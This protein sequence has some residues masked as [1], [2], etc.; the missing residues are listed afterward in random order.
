MGKK[1]ALEDTPAFFKV[2]LGNFPK[3][4]QIPPAF[5]KFFYGKPLPQNI[6]LQ[7][8]EKSL[9]QVNVVKIGNKLF[10]KKGWRA[11]VKDNSLELG[12]FV[13]FSY[14]G[15]SIFGFTIFGRN[16]C[17]KD[18]TAVPRKSDKFVSDKGMEKER[19]TTMNN[20]QT[21]EDGILGNEERNTEMSDVDQRGH[22]RMLDN[23][24]RLGKVS[25][26]N[27]ANQCDSKIDDKPVEIKIEE[28]DEEDAISVEFVEEIPKS[29][30]K[31]KRT[32]SLPSVPSTH[33]KGKEAGGSKVARSER[34]AGSTKSRGNSGVKRN[35]QNRKQPKVLDENV[36]TLTREEKY[37]A[38]ERAKRA[39][40]SKNPYTMLVIQPSC[41]GIGLNKSNTNIPLSFVKAY[42][43][44]EHNNVIVQLP[45]GKAWPMKYYVPKQA[46]RPAKLNGGWPAFALDNHLAVGDVCVFELI[47]RTENILRVKIF[48]Y[49]NNQ[50]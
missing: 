41:I 46:N 3:Q 50:N 29:G 34:A 43:N 42:F 45:D 2:L 7:N 26:K 8:S 37:L 25:D 19:K 33:P 40:K 6:K 44:M 1:P 12:D 38:L 35:A 22:G 47:N 36:R 32:E 23:E 15:R 49:M 48:K 10:F 20:Q 39:F 4:L 11:F 24:K 27:G 31:R 13:V 30:K 28:I 21:S 17:E 5:A 18:V 9:W 16:A 14:V